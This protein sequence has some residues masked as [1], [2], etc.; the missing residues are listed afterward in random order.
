M[1]LKAA[2]GVR[3]GERVDSLEAERTRILTLARQLEE[4]EAGYDH[5]RSLF[6]TGISSVA[7]DLWLPPTGIPGNRGV[8]EGNPSGEYLPTSWPLT[9]AGFVTQPP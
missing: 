9:E 4:V 5:I 6:G 2:Q 3:L 8:G 1:A 7:P